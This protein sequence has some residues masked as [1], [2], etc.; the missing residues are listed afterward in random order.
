MPK[1]GPMRVRGVNLVLSQEDRV[2]MTTTTTSLADGTMVDRVAHFDLNHEISG[3]G[4]QKAVAC[5]PVRQNALQ[6]T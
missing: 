6:E 1:G 4:E 2:P 5:W 3:R